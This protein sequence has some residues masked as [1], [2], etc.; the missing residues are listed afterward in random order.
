MKKDKKEEAIKAIPN[1]YF[2]KDFN[3]VQT[4]GD[5]DFILLGS[6]DVQRGNN[7]VSYP[8]L[9]KQIFDPSNYYTATSI[10]TNFLVKNLQEGDNVKLT[11]TA[12]TW[13]IDASNAACSGKEMF[14]ASVNSD[15]VTREIDGQGKLLWNAIATD[16]SW[17][18]IGGYTR[19]S[20]DKKNQ[21][22][23][24]QYLGSGND[25][26]FNIDFDYKTSTDG[27]A[28]WIQTSKVSI[29]T[30]NR[31][32]KGI[33]GSVG[34]YGGNN[35]LV[36]NLNSRTLDTGVQVPCW[37]DF[38]AS[39]FTLGSGK[40]NINTATYYTKTQID[41]KFGSYYDKTTTDNK[42]ATK[43][44]WQVKSLVNGTNITVSNNNGAWTIN[45][46]AATTIIDNLIST[47]A[48]AALSANQGNVLNTIKGDKIIDPDIVV[49]KVYGEAAALTSQS[50]FRFSLSLTLTDWN[51]L[52]TALGTLTPPIIDTPLIITKSNNN[53]LSVNL[54]SI[55]TTYNYAYLCLYLNGNKIKGT[56][57]LIK[58][59]Q[60][61]PEEVIYED[62][63]FRFIIESSANNLLTFSVIP[64]TGAI[65]YFLSTLGSLT[66]SQ[67]DILYNYILKSQYQIGIGNKNLIDIYNSIDD[68]INKKPFANKINTGVGLKVEIYRS[69]NSY[70][71]GTFTNHIK[72]VFNLQE[73]QKFV[74]ALA[75]TA[76]YTADELIHT[77]ITDRAQNR[78]YVAIATKHYADKV[79]IHAGWNE[80]SVIPIITVMIGG[81]IDQIVVE[82]SR[83]WTNNNYGHGCSWNKDTLTIERG[84][85][86]DDNTSWAITL[87][88]EN[89]YSDEWLKLLVPALNPLDKDIR[90]CLYD[91]NIV[92]DGSTFM[93]LSDVQ[94]EVVAFQEQMEGLAETVD[95]NKTE[96]RSGIEGL[97]QEKANK[98]F[99]SSI[100][101]LPI[102]D[103]STTATTGIIGLAFNFPGKNLNRL[104]AGF[105]GVPNTYTDLMSI[106][107]P[108]EESTSHNIAV[109]RAALGTTITLSVAY[110]ANN[111]LIP[112]INVTRIGGGDPSIIY[113]SSTNTTQDDMT[114]SWNVG[115]YLTLSREGKKKINVRGMYS[116]TTT[117]L[118][119]MMKMHINNSN[120]IENVIETYDLINVHDEFKNAYKNIDNALYG[121]DY[122][123]NL[124]YRDP[125]QGNVVG[126]DW[127]ANKISSSSVEATLKVGFIS[128]DANNDPFGMVEISDHINN[129]KRRIDALA[130]GFDDS[131]VPSTKDFNTS[132]GGFLISNQGVFNNLSI[133]LVGALLANDKKSYIL[134][135]AILFSGSRTSYSW[136]QLSGYFLTTKKEAAHCYVSITYDGNQMNI[137]GN[138]FEQAGVDVNLSGDNKSIILTLK[139]TTDTFV[140]GYFCMTQEIV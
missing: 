72:Y 25:T 90:I 64:I 120:I 56:N 106:E 50:G 77:A 68:K 88:G 105:A 122:K 91:V 86:A 44:D 111:I 66:T 129:K 10:N 81:T 103:I 123:C 43:T 24:H 101:D 54:L 31:D 19:T 119:V 3:E 16:T 20:T 87:E 55:N 2:P 92:D 21:Y 140:K 42:Y 4:G 83:A 58:G 48:T 27:G 36:R 99:H 51:N 126:L 79:V 17:E 35:V 7:V 67:E 113:Y 49:Q 97:A 37:N 115:G 59:E 136:R 23:V 40:I 76:S 69:N 15:T 30:D 78:S 118:N 125:S 46:S 45:S 60:V 1:V 107:L 133:P 28:T 39:D 71:K 8:N 32:S 57:I 102:T 47:S 84:H 52:L 65:K 114:I 34:V 117:Y 139:D 62:V 26:Y 18:K 12:G 109:R 29:G 70:I 108:G 53:T 85:P 75:H 131:Q 124:Y 98:I 73:V 96:F 80:G 61:F 112:L 94:E 89:P 38:N 5:K 6:K 100:E 63:S 121:T 134:L 137:T 13:K 130:L 41:T 11:N 82:A 127:W 132:L 22:Q 128:R 110:K 116:D 93:D 95:S 135:M 14:D 9:S 74:D 104:F 33:T 138:L